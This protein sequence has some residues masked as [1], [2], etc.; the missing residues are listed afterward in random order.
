M[1]LETK[2]SQVEQGHELNLMCVQNSGVHSTLLLLALR[3][4]DVFSF[5]KGH[6]ELKN[7][8]S[9]SLSSWIFKLHFWNAWQKHLRS[10]HTWRKHCRKKTLTTMVFARL[11]GPF[12]Q[13]EFLSIRACIE[14]R[15]TV[16]GWNPTLGMYKALLIT[17]Q[18]TK[19]SN[20]SAIS[21]GQLQLKKSAGSKITKLYSS[22]VSP[23]FPFWKG[24]HVF[25]ASSVAEVLR[26]NPG[27]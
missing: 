22:I 12:G 23:C 21:N 3:L 6:W 15:G 14:D 10:M 26:H 25:Y 16:D 13:V 5:S 2:Y 11:G 9:L 20:F 18:A 4:M 17:W 24:K 27:C 19:P 1:P 8:V 7:S